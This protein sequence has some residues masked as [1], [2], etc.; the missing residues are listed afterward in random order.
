MDALG[1]DR[2]CG[3][4]GEQIKITISTPTPATIDD[5]LEALLAISATERCVL[6]ANCGCDRPRLV[7]LHGAPVFMDDFKV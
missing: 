5:T 1:T 3:R 6:A 4:C 7:G 2:A